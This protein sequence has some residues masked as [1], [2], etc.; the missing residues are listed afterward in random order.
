MLLQ[1]VHVA[2]E[3]ILGVFRHTISGNGDS[4]FN[5]LCR[6]QLDVATVYRSIERAV[7]SQEECN[8]IRAID[9]MEA[10]FFWSEVELDLSLPRLCL[11]RWRL[12]CHSLVL[13]KEYIFRALFILSNTLFFHHISMFS[14]SRASDN[15]R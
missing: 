15:C 11:S 7:G 13:E 4:N 5:G 8:C 6:R 3:D 2:L 14:D 10:R 12:G 9:T 1:G